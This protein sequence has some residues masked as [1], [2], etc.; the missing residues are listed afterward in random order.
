[1]THA[2]ARPVADT[3]ATGPEKNQRGMGI[4]MLY[5]VT[6]FTGAALLFMVQPLA[7]KLILPSFG[8]SATVWSTSSLFFQVLLLLGYLYAHLSTHR[9]GAYWQPRSHVLVLLVPL[10]ALPVALPSNAAPGADDSP[11]V[12]LLRI[13]AVMV[14]L[15]FLVL[16]ATG[17]LIQRWYS[18]SDGPRADDPYFLFAGSNLGS[19]VGLLSYPLLIEPTLTLSQQRLGWSWAFVAF[20]VLMGVCAATVRSPRGVQRDVVPAAEEPRPP[21]PQLLTWGALA[22]LPSCLMLAVTSHISTDVAPIPLVWV[23]PLAVYLA[24][25]VAAFARTSRQPPV[26][27]TRLAVASAF[28]AGVVSL[29]TVSLP[30]IVVVAL[31]IALVALVG[32]AAHAR[33]ATTR[34]A[35]GQL[36]AFYLVISV[37]G[38]LGGLV[39]GVVAPLLFNR[40]W[41]YG[42]TLAAVPLLMLGVSAKASNWM[43]RRYHPAFRLVVGLVLTLV[44][45]LSAAVA[46]VS[47]AKSGIVVALLIIVV[48]GAVGWFIA[49]APVVLALSLLIGTAG[50][51]V[52]AMT[53]AMLTERTFYG[54]YRVTSGDGMHKLVHGTTVHGIQ[55]WDATKRT[56]PT[57][58]Y[59]QEGPLGQVM[60]EVKRTRTGI[61]GLGAGGIA[62]YAGAGDH[63]TFYEIDPAIARIAEDPRYFSYLEDSP[64][65][66]D[67]VL[68]DGRLKLEEEPEGEFDLLILDAFSSDSIPVHLLTREALSLYLSRL[69]PDGTLVVHV[70]N[71][72]FDLKPVVGDVASDLGLVAMAGRGGATERADSTP[73][74]WIVLTHSRDLEARL[75]D[76]GWSQLEPDG[77]RVW[78]DDYA[79]VLSA[80]RW[81]VDRGER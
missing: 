27:L 75:R 44:V 65:S 42:L 51:G 36:T 37:G 79:S 41:E 16:S 52:Q 11:A 20:L 66:V 62:T 40:V 21:W 39:N 28:L 3:R 2:D 49:R 6:A 22:F 77:S 70:S 23:L 33:L 81:S 68:G 17:P 58:Y 69:K 50:I 71:R 1:V 59:A 15:P 25:F 47:K 76:K 53:A 74:E 8:G 34:P 4:A 30:I 14:G 48:V 31:D 64:A 78:T 61:V 10:L 5:A 24:S 29:A 56:I 35:P 7:A 60:D 55:W 19:F 38:A 9:F 67:V 43:T 63:Y 26:K 57:A 45:M 46:I 12:W 18:W 54:S 32:Y 73:S 80:L 72:I 13:L